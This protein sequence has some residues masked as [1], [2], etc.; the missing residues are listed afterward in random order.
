MRIVMQLQESAGDMMVNTG[1]PMIQRRRLG[2]ELR[3][4]R[5]AARLTIG[6]VAEALGCSPST[7]SRIET[8][9]VCASPDVV[10][11][12]AELYGCEPEQRDRLVQHA[13][14]ARARGWWY[15]Y[16]DVDPSRSRYVRLESEAKQIYTYEAL[17]VPGLLQTPEYARAV[18]T[19]LRPDLRPDQVS[20]WVEFRE[21][22]QALLR[23]D[24][25]PAVWAVVD[26]AALH[27][28]A[29]GRQVMRQQ[30]RRL[31]DDSALDAVTLQVL[32]FRAGEH[33]AMH[34]SFTILGFRDPDQPD[35]VYL[36]NAATDHCL[37]Q[38]RKL[39]RFARAFQR[40]RRSALDPIASTL[41][42]TEL[43]QEL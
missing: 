24:D 6:D 1:N 38:G 36:E 5:E 40:L 15:D 9:H 11:K 31:I 2:T 19:A 27:R 16:N 22:R 39:R 33:A 23:R 42:L 12:L 8:A 29:G 4:R 7:V 14:A 25:P 43:L 26:E 21:I 34:G 28:P 41:R 18:I 10:R 13:W 37:Q 17:L 35:V 20:R 30:L 32:P 3:R